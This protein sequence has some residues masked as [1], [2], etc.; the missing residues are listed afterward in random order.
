M[1]KKYKEGSELEHEVQTWRLTV[2]YDGSHFHGWQAQPG[3]PT[4][5]GV[6]QEALRAFKKGDIEVQGAG[7]T[8]AGVHALGQVA[9]CSFPSD[10]TERKML[11]A[12][13]SLLP[14]TVRIMKAER[15]PAG[16]NAKHHSIGKR[17]LYRVANTDVVSPFKAPYAWQV[18]A[19]LDVEK[20]KTAAQCLLGEKDFESFRSVHCD[21]GHARR[22][23]WKAE[24]L[25]DSEDLSIEIRGNA[26]CRN[27]IRII[28]GTLVE[29]G[30]GKIA[31][32]QMPR[33]IDAKN[34]EAAGITAPAH[35]LFLGTVYYPDQ[36]DDACIPSTAV[37]PNHP[38]GKDFWPPG[39]KGESNK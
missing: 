17:Y 26:F 10:L 20:M 34:R 4:V 5:Q 37:F 32:E 9:S 2:A 28:A 22:F 3:L 8:D 11:L 27:M 15:M 35:G 18:K 38:W 30:R 16:F 7:R 13:A 33:I 6:L 1:I 19:S 24:V 39:P 29:V 36:L 21:A 31:V 25:Q 14:P 12:M 23:L